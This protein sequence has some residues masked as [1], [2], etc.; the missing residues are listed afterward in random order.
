MLH[1]PSFTD[2]KQ[3]AKSTNKKKKKS[4]SY[5]IFSLISP[6]GSLIRLSWITFY[7]PTKPATIIFPLMF[8]EQTG[9]V[10]IQPHTMCWK[11]ECPKLQL[12]HNGFVRT[13][14]EGTAKAWALQTSRAAQ[15]PPSMTRNFSME[16]PGVSQVQVLSFFLLGP[17]CLKHWNVRTKKELIRKLQQKNQAKTKKQTNQK[18]QLNKLPPP[19]PL[20]F[21]MTHL[22]ETV[23]L[24]LCHPHYILQE[25]VISSY[26]L[27]FTE[28]DSE[29][30]ARNVL[31]RSFRRN[32]NNFITMHFQCTFPCQ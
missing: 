14:K 7:F 9:L 30:L 31:S 18:N 26:N 6:L 8:L 5:T 29:E 22:E 16:M 24:S 21:P 20:S 12:H 25:K 27:V 28:K 10:Q 32:I 15:F 11:A 2:L 19:N 3:F 1:P 13:K 23:A 17:L 4:L